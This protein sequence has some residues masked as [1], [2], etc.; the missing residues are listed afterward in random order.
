M[1]T[2]QTKNSESNRED[3]LNTI[4]TDQLTRLEIN[5]RRKY[6]MGAEQAVIFIHGIKCQFNEYISDY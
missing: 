5:D 4:A 3:I 1:L 2:N 6:K